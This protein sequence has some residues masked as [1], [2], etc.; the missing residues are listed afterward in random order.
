MKA[1]KLTRGINKLG[2]AIK[3]SSPEILI[4]VGTVG[5]VAS[6]ILAC[7]ETL[8]VVDVL[9]ETKDTLD[10]IHTSVGLDMTEEGSVRKYTEEDA[11]G[12]TV[13]VYAKTAVEMAKIYWPAVVVSTT[14]VAC[15]LASNGIMKKRN[16]AL[17]SAYAS[18]DAAFKKYRN[19]V[20]EK[21]GEDVDKISRFGITQETVDVPVGNGETGQVTTNVVTKYDLSYSDYAKFFDESSVYWSKDPEENL[22]ILKEIELEANEQ[23]MKKGY[24]YLNEVYDLLGIEKTNAGRVVGWIYDEKNPIGDNLVDFGMYDSSNERKRMFINGYERSILLDF[25]VD[26]VITV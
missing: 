3:K 4:A 18:V 6:L 23:L 25:N 16:A 8:K 21:Y 19:N 26:G 12:D 14:S 22:R 24:L 11:K 5:T 10:R 2:F 20:K 9:E 17:V 15:F 1:S 7:K 13:K